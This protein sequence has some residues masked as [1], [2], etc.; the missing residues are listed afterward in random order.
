MDGTLETDSTATILKKQRIDLAKFK[1]KLQ[2]KGLWLKENAGDGNCFFRAIADQIYGN[3][4][5]HVT[6]RR[7]VI[8]HLKANK[9]EFKLFM[10]NDMKIEK[11][12]NLMSRDGAWGGQLEMSILAQIHKFNVILH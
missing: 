6:L 10:E 9:E 1:V 11:Y 12:I 8:D 2:K 5:R 7:E 4:Y 3:E